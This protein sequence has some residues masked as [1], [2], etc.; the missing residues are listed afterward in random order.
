MRRPD[1]SAG[2]VFVYVCVS[3]SVTGEARLVLVG[4]GAD[5]NTALPT[6]T[7]SGSASDAAAKRLENVRAVDR[8]GAVGAE[9]SRDCGETT[10]ER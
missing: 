4:V 6:G 5:G 7:R 10:V 2:V 1:S 8:V 3:I 9:G